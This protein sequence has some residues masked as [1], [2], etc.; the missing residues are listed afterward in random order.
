MIAEAVVTGVATRPNSRL[1]ASGCSDGQIQI[2]D[3]DTGNRIAHVAGHNESV[4]DVNFS[5]DGFQLFSCSLDKTVK[6]WYLSL[7]DRSL[8]PGGLYTGNCICS[9]IFEGHWVSMHRQL[10]LAH[11]L[12]QDQQSVAAVAS[13]PDDNLVLSCSNDRTV[14]LWD[15]YSGKAV[16]T[17]AGHAAPIISVAASPAAGYFA[18]G[19]GDMTA[20]IWKYS[21]RS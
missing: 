14:M 5:A 17:L 16:L 6:A 21:I 7:P 1:V 20:K 8:R 2:W 3:I 15:C 11:L 4:Y 12:I 9:R 19:S 13:T 10:P 18:T